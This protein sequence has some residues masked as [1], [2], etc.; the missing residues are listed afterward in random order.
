MREVKS[1]YV[2]TRV[3][4]EI[5]DRKTKAV[6]SEK[7]H[8]DVNHIVSKA[9]KTGQLPVLMNRPDIS[10]QM[11][12]SMTYQ[13]ALN[14]VVFAQQS[15]ERLPSSVR[16]YFGNKPENMLKALEQAGD[17]PKIK[18]ALQEMKILNEDASVAP[19]VEENLE[20]V[21]SSVETASETA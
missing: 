11:P 16:A 18:A 4:T 15:F 1:A 14:K 8:S 10:Q 21:S 12:S 17:N 6:Q 19:P 3:I 13:E 2:R 5:G 20:Q 7:K 9:M